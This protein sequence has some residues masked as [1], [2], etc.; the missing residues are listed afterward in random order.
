MLGDWMLYKIFQCDLLTLTNQFKSDRISQLQRAT[1]EFLRWAGH[2]SDKTFTFQGYMYSLLSYFVMWTWWWE[3]ATTHWSCLII[4]SHHLK[5]IVP[6]SYKSHLFSY[7]DVPKRTKS[8]FLACHILCL[9]PSHL[10]LNSVDFSMESLFH[11]TM[12]LNFFFH[13]CL[14]NWF[15]NMAGLDRYKPTEW[16]K[17]STNGFF[18]CFSC[19]FFSRGLG[20]M[21]N[22]VTCKNVWNENKRAFSHDMSDF[23]KP[24]VN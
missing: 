11:V 6:C 4:F 16:I 9:L 24:F 20:R 13:E 8:L 18:D 2:A 23:M 14:C 21:S 5:R 15:K 17:E 22:I 10:C 7:G 1:R 3:K 12:L 19:I